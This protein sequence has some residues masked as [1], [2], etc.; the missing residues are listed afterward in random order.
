MKYYLRKVIKKA[1]ISVKQNA[2]KKSELA[3]KLHIARVQK[4]CFAVMKK[5]ALKRIKAKKVDKKIDEIYSLFQ[6]KRF[7]GA[8]RT[9]AHKHAKIHTIGEKKHPHE[10]C[11]KYSEFCKCIKCVQIRSKFD[12]LGPVN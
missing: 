10:F 9:V 7:F 1:M 11:V 6:T 8:W 3:R 12:A 4:K 5:I 2:F